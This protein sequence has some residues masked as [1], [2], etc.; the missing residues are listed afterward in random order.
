LPRKLFEDLEVGARF[1]GERY[2]VPEAEMI[3]F[4]RKWDPRPIHVDDEAARAAGFGRAIASGAYTTAVFTLLAM[5]SRQ[6]DGEHAVIAGLGARMALPRPVRGGDELEY[7]A[8][9]TDK[10]TSRSRPDAGIVTTRARLYNQHDEVVYESTT[11]T[12]VARREPGSD[13]LEREHR[14]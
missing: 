6:A 2:V 13:A 12:L 14:D 10:R 4:A 8:E 7:R 1:G 9:I 5:R 3:A 11:A